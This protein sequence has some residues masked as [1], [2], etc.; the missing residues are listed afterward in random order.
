MT[1][2]RY[3]A[4][5]SIWSLRWYSLLILT[6]VLFVGTGCDKAAKPDPP[7]GPRFF[8]T[9]DSAGKELYDA[10][11][12]GNSDAVLA[13]FGTDAKDYLLTGNTAD[14]QKAMSAFAADYDQM[15][16]WS[17][18]EKGGM[19]LN[20]GIEN[21]PFPF[22]LKKN[23]SGQWHFDAAG[24]REEFAARRI[25][26]NELT[27]LEVLHQGVVAQK[28]YFSKLQAGEKTRHYAEKIRSQE[29]KHDGLFWEPAAGEA[30]S[31][32]GPL[33]ARASTEGF[34][35]NAGSLLPFHGY[36]YRILKE[37]GPS[38]KGGEHSYRV[39]G[40]MTRGFAILA[41]PAEY[42]ASGVMTFMVDQ[43]GVI[44]QK[45]LGPNTVDEAKAIT[46][47]D[48]DESWSMAE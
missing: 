10:A 19:V 13:I 33:A 46:K 45:D 48:P 18:L 20:V 12:S 47:F 27:V 6:T 38:A 17:A 28:E 21:Y 40:D 36:Y 29:G 42:R 15:H 30:D 26:D 32:L 43:D 1:Q 25:G 7:E 8:A 2:S 9:P 37:Q 41:Y 24:A 35:T 34:D 14:D 31:P 4:V 23:A 44:F 11:K 22:P 5:Q 39:N 16:R 3:P